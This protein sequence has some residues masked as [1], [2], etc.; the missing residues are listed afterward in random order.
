MFCEKKGLVK[1]FYYIVGEKFY[2][3]GKQND[4]EKF[5]YA[6]RLERKS[7]GIE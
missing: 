6:R 2:R 1:E 5:A 3:D 4:A 7:N